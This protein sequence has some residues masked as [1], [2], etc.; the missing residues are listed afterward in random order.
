MLLNSTVSLAIVQPST[1]SQP[2]SSAQPAPGR[3]EFL[4]TVSQPIT[5]PPRPT[6]LT[7]SPLTLP[8]AIVTAFFLSGS[9]FWALAKATRK[10]SSKQS[11]DTVQFQ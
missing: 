10:A 7:E 1:V 2:A 11:A 6:N 4:T 8:I 5:Q 9:V 3:S